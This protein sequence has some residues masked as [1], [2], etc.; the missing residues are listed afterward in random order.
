MGRSEGLSNGGISGRSG[1]KILVTHFITVVGDCSL[2]DEEPKEE[3]HGAH[4]PSW[5]TL[6]SRIGLS[7]DGVGWLSGKTRGKCVMKRG[8][9]F[10]VEQK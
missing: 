7:G 3:V 4:H 10:V 5:F 6:A 8:K 2:V 9:L 1:A